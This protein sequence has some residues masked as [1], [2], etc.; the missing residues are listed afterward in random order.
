MQKTARGVDEWSRQEGIETWYTA[1]GVTSGL[2]VVGTCRPHDRLLWNSAL[3]GLDSRFNRK[4]IQAGSRVSWP[5]GNGPPGFYADFRIWFAMHF[6][7]GLLVGCN[8]DF[9]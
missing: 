1:N 9:I 8:A 4:L 7:S 2:Q 5:L 3:R 6:N